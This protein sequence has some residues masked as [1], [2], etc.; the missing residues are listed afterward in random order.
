MANFNL[1]SPADFARLTLGSAASVLATFNNGQAANWDIFEA[2]YISTA[3]L[4][5]GGTPVKFLI[6]TQ[7]SS[8]PANY[9]A[10]VNQIMDNFGRRKT[11]FQ[12]PYRDGQ[13]TDDLGRSPQKF[14][15]EALLFGDQYLLG[16][17]MLLGE[18][19]DPTPG[20]LAHPIYGEIQVVATEF[21]LTHS[22]EK[23]K[24]VAIKLNFEEHNFSI[25]QISF[26]DKTNDTSK[27]GKLAAL[28][29]AFNKISAA[30]NTV[31]A[32]LTAIQ[33]TKN[34]IK[35]ALGDFK[36]SYAL[37]SAQLNAAFNGGQASIPGLLPVNEGG[38][39]GAGGTIVAANPST[40]ISPTDPFASVPSGL[41]DTT[42]TALVAQSI[43]KNIQVNR[44]ALSGIIAS[45]EAQN[46]G[47][48]AL[49]LHD[50]I[51][52][53]KSTAV[54]M[55]E[56]YEAGVAS[57][58]AHVIQYVTPWDMSVREIAYR[59]GLTPENG[60]DI[61]LLNPSLQSLNL[62]PKGTSLK[63]AVS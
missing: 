62:V 26:D 37:I 40:V 16:L 54:T 47:N 42:Q 28:S 60:I 21:S 15:F 33:S 36:D 53:L 24:A 43:Q 32:N 6:F 22:S 4:Q 9:H 11:K 30:I 31:G 7:D 51:L 56:A 46:N 18:L 13:T 48:G 10:A 23:R 58:N 45:I 63:V 34:A 2:S 17:Q 61:A 41:T 29:S 25:A 35:R 55:Q 8:D 3:S 19:N 49:E 5:N 14:E 20:I 1:N 52:D 50:T 12:Y 38:L 27:T 39:Q 44:D 57:S 59:N